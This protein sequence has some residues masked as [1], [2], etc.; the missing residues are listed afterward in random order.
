MSTAGTLGVMDWTVSTQVL[1]AS[2]TPSW[3][4]RTVFRASFCTSCMGLLA[5]ALPPACRVLCLV[6]CSVLLALALAGHQRRGGLDELVGELALAGEQLLGEVVTAGHDVVRLR[7]PLG[8]RQVDCGDLRGD[9]LNALNH[10]LDRVEG[11]LL[12]L[13]DHRQELV[14]QFLRSA[15]GAGHCLCLPLSST[16]NFTKQRLVCQA[17]ALDLIC[18]GRCGRP[19]AAAR[20]LVP[21]AFGARRVAGFGALLAADGLGAAGLG[22]A[23][24]GA[25]ALG[26][27]AAGALGA[28]VAT[29]FGAAGSGAAW[30]AGFGAAGSG[31]AWATTCRAAWAV[32]VTAVFAAAAVFSAAAAASFL[33]TSCQAR[34][35]LTGISGSVA[36]SRSSANLRW[37]A[38]RCSAKS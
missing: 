25:G 31:A 34:L 33:V 26:A 21:V 28:V 1:I 10:S 13:A 38:S 35:L 37:M 5:M 29:A 11:D 2:M 19:L 16:A 8:E 14:L 9:G 20:Q 36:A 27:V 7:Q 22:A 23:G 32:S 17:V 3:L 6:S 24:L 18:G 12:A 30:A 15:G 4:L